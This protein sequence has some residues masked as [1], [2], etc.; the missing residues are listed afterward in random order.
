MQQEKLKISVIIIT[1][2]QE[3]VIVRSIDSVLK[4][5]EYLYEL[6]ICDDCS[7]DSTWE[8]IT[9]YTNRF[10]TLIK[11]YKNEKNLGIFGNIENTW[12]KPTGN[13]IFYLSGDDSFCDGILKAAVD[14]VNQRNINV[15]D[16][17]FTLY[18]DFKSIS[19]SGD[20]RV[21]RNDYLLKNDDVIGLKLRGLIIN[22]TTAISKNVL[23]KFKPVNHEIGIYADGLIDIQT[24]LYS[25]KNYYSPIVG[26]IY[27]S[28]IGIASKTS[29]D[30]HLKSYIRLMD[31]YLKIF[32]FRGKK[33]INC[34]LYNKQKYYYKFKPSFK[35]WIICSVRYLGSIELKYGFR[36]IKD[37]AIMLTKMLLKLVINY[38]VKNK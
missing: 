24:Q 23:R 37:N 3:D 34:I 22:R 35:S 8:I 38:F 16:E 18:F 10:P 25:D 31:E 14:L 17:Y 7:K 26:S 19:I 21:F 20:E 32:S 36:P 1:Y 13:L 30:E 6:V 2:N 27:Y 12:S 15:K 9:A 29:N 4:Q 11:P 33:T 5:K 28:G